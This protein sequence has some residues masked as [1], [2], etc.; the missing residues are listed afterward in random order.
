MSQNVSSAAV[1]LGTLRV[2]IIRYTVIPA[3]RDSDLLFCLQLLRK[4]NVYTLL[5]LT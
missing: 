3:K 1:V 4:N 2:K 5:G